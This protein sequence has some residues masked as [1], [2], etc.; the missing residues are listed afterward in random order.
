MILLLTWQQITAAIC[1]YSTGWCQ[2]SKPAEQRAVYRPKGVAGVSFICPSL[3]SAFLKALGTFMLSV[4]LPVLPASLLFQLLL[5]ENWDLWATNFLVGWCWM[6]CS[7]KYIRS[8]YKGPVYPTWRCP[9]CH[10]T[11]ARAWRLALAC[12]TSHLCIMGECFYFTFPIWKS[13]A[14]RGELQTQFCKMPGSN[15]QKGPLKFIL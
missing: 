5:L 8:P 9:R 6:Q 13:E 11:N 10:H 12:T 7:E 14:H 15:V 1:I 3:S 4:T 2:N